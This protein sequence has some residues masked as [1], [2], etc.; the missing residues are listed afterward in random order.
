MKQQAVYQPPFA[1]IEGRQLLKH[2]GRCRCR[3]DDGKE[4]V[5]DF[6]RHIYRCKGLTAPL[7]YSR[8]RKP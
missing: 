6:L 5:P 3:H 2:D 7:E 1:T 4:S 8:R